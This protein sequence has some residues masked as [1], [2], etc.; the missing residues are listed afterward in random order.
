M[1]REKKEWE[2]KAGARKKDAGEV[3]R[4]LRGEE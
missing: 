2:Y 1:F 4:V 3:D